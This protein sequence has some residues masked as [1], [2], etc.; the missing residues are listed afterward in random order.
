MARRFASFVLLGILV[1]V[2][3]AP[4]AASGPVCPM[5]RPAALLCV[6]CD[7]AAASNRATTVSAGSCCRY[8]AASATSP[9]PGVIPLLQ[10]AQDS[11]TA[12]VTTLAAGPSGDV[13]PAPAFP[14]S[15][16]SSL[17]ST[18]SPITRN[19]ALRL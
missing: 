8:E 15:H 19:I 9:T 11:G 2:Q 12:T 17:R 1:T 4:L 6:G 7:V 10:R 13:I 18:D 16:P 14:S 5:E 3:A